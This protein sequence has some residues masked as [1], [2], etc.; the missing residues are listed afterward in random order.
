MSYS[1]QVDFSSYL[2]E[3][4]SLYSKLGKFNNKPLV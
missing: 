4:T 2:A 3:F 1:F